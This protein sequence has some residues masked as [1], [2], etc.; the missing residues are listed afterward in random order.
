MTPEDIT[1][2]IKRA[3]RADLLNI[4]G[5]AMTALHGRGHDMTPADGRLNGDLADVSWLEAEGAW[6]PVYH[7]SE[8]AELAIQPIRTEALEGRM[9]TYDMT[10]IGDRVRYADNALTY[11]NLEIRWDAENADGTLGDPNVEQECGLCGDELDGTEGPSATYRDQP[12]GQNCAHLVNPTVADAIDFFDREV[13]F[14]TGDKAF[15]AEEKLELLALAKRVAHRGSTDGRLTV[16]SVHAA[17][18]FI[19]NYRQG[20]G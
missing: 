14:L 9:T 11:L 5:W 13:D 7:T 17:G 10:M 15:E 12:I 1:G 2:A 4:V 18:A 20:R 6:G 19:A 16:R 8:S 3:T